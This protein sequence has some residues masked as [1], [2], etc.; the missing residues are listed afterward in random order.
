MTQSDYLVGMVEVLVFTVAIAYA[1]TR[2]R[3]GLLPAWG[4]AIGRLTEIVFWV[5][6]V[7]LLSEALGAIGLF[8]RVPLLIGAAGIAAGAR[9]WGQRGARDPD[10]PDLRP[11]LPRQERWAIPLAAVISAVVFA[12]WLLVARPYLDMGVWGYD[13]L[14]YHMPLAA[15]FAQ[16]G[17]TVS[18]HHLEPI[19]LSAYTPANSELIHGIGIVMV[20][21]DVLS[22]LINF[23]WL[24]LALLAAWCVGR[25]F[26]VGLASLMAVAI[27][28]ITASMLAEQPG[29]AY[30]DT[31]S[32][33]LLLSSV[34][35]VVNAFSAEEDTGSLVAA[36]IPAGLAA[37]LAAGTKVLCLAPVAALSIGVIVIAGTRLRRHVG[38]YWLLA[39]VSTGGYWYARNLVVTGNPLPWLKV[40]LGPLSLNSPESLDWSR[41]EPSLAR[42]I[43]DADIWRDYIA[44]GFAIGFGHPWYLVM[45]LALAGALG[46]VFWADSRAIR[47]VGIVAVL[48]LLAYVI[49]PVTGAGPIGAP[50]FMAQ[51]DRFANPALTLGLVVLP[52]IPAIRSSEWRAPIVLLLGVI[53]A[54]RFHFDQNVEVGTAILVAG[55]GVIGVLGAAAVAR[56]WSRL[57][58]TI[59]A[60]AIAAVAIAAYWQHSENYFHDRYLNV[61]PGL[62]VSSSFVWA[63]GVKD[64]RIAIAGTTATSFQYGY[65]GKDVSNRVIY[66][67]RHG[68]YGAITPFETC[69]EW[70][71]AINE[72]RFDYLVTSPTV[73]PNAG[74]LYMPGFSPEDSWTSTDPAAQLILRDGPVAVYRLTGPLNPGGCA[75]LKPPAFVGLPPLL[76]RP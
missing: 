43:L 50:V 19:L 26:G 22:P 34:A 51:A 60:C 24:G 70:R 61:L 56:S 73:N 45:G 25:P 13:S 28:L 68:R 5:A 41:P 74:E 36:M 32:L 2:I 17:S 16:T 12:K 69:E 58:R 3:A 11:A 75:E 65:Y 63:E 42:Y 15:G 29:N 76:H 37:G 62:S 6:L 53:L 49:T 40:G 67:G 54:S 9:W 30:S 1:A 20:Q 4:G 39:L 44:P 64:A 48:S 72:G 47:M 31:A 7:V 27:L 23:A 8:K 10:S 46:A 14:T 57:E 35:I 52:T 18:I 71:M 66:V 38:R 33:A 55:S 21:S 59:A